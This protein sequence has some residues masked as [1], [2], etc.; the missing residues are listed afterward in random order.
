MTALRMHTIENPPIE[1]DGPPFFDRS[2]EQPIPGESIMDDLR[3]ELMKS[4]YTPY[5][6]GLATGIDGDRIATFVADYG[7]PVCD[8]T[9]NE[10][11]RLARLMEMCLVHRDQ[12]G[13]CEEATLIAEHYLTAHR[14][15]WGD[16]LVAARVTQAKIQSN[17]P[18]ACCGG[19]REGD[20]LRGRD[21]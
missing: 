14:A 8:L 18:V 3:Y 19:I 6:I 5:G 15:G 4:E 13:W 7:R 9:M 20:T 12:P 10:A 16:T 1:K 11:T 17:M 21:R 2:L